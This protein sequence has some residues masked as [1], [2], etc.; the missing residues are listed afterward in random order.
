VVDGDPDPLVLTEPPPVVGDGAGVVAGAPPPAIGVPGVGFPAGPEVEVDSAH[1]I[2]V[3]VSMTTEVAPDDVIV[4]VEVIRTVLVLVLSKS[5]PLFFNVARSRLFSLG[6][7]VV[8]V[9]V[10]DVKEAAAMTV[11]VVA[12]VT[13]VS[14]KTE[15]K[16]Q[17]WPSK[18]VLS[19]PSGFMNGV[20]LFLTSRLAFQF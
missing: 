10:V 16:Y 20:T 2:T 5:F 11:V 1:E 7:V 18:L 8:V 12:S 13:V 15:R 17:R 19:M 9:Y 14:G 6:Q 3:F 4:T